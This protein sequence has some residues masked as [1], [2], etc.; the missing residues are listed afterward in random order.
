MNEKE[1]EETFVIKSY[2]KADLAHLYHPNLPVPYAMSKLR[3][4]IRKNKELYVR[5]YQ[6]GE[7]KN[8]HSYTRRQV[9]LIIHYLDIP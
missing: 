8:D 7:G 6:G 2:L 3:S 1:V 4:W 5:M 9:C